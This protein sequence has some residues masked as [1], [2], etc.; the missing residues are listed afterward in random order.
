MPGQQDPKGELAITLLESLGQAGSICV[1]SSYMNG[2][3][4]SSGWRRI[5][6]RYG[7]DLKRVVAR[8]W[9]LRSLIIR[10]HGIIPPL[11]QL[12]DQ[13]RLTG[14]HAVP[15]LCA[16]WRFGMGAWRPVNTAA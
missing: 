11:G 13:S 15:E 5:S 2:R 12:P 4:S 1:Y 14:R 8:L 9:D 6:R 7:K 16:T 10:D 3:S